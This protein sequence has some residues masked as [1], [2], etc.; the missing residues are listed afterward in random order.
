MPGIGRGATLLERIVDYL[1]T[2]IVMPRCVAFAVAAWVLAAWLTDVWDRFGHLGITSP[3]KGCGKST[4]LDLLE[5]LVPNPLLAASIS[6]AAMYRAIEQMRPTLLLDEAQQLSSGRDDTSAIREL[7]NAGIGKG[8]AVYRMGGAQWDELKRF[9]VYSPKI[10]A[11]IGDLDPVLGDRSLPVRLNRKTKSDVVQRV[12]ISEV[13]ERGAKLYEEIC[14]WVVDQL[15]GDE[16]AELYASLPTFDIANDRMADCLRPL[17]VVAALQGA[18]WSELEEYAKTIDK[19]DRQEER[20]SDG[21][22]LLAACREELAGR[23][24]LGT[25]ELIAALVNRIDEPWATCNR[26]RA[27][28]GNWLARRLRDFDIKPRHDDRKT[29]RGYHTVD[30]ASAWTTYLP[31][32]CPENPSSPSNPSK[33]PIY[34]SSNGTGLGHWTGDPSGD[35]SPTTPRVRAVTPFPLTKVVVS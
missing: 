30:F 23:E 19:R 31:A 10:F 5:Q 18:G 20:Q 21:V 32:P 12:V 3:E 9:S 29:Q 28:D 34:N 6:P 24:F 22:R 2:Y 7:L 4:L 15:A 17:Q 14:E 8:A 1:L 26:G 27:I 13:Q 11:L 35:A 33:S 16:A 25:S